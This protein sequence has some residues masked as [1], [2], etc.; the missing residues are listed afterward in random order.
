MT[1]FD[2]IRR[3]ESRGW[4]KFGVC[5]KESWGTV[6]KFGNES[7]KQNLYEYILDLKDS[8]KASQVVLCQEVAVVLAALIEDVTNDQSMAGIIA[9]A[10]QE[11]R[12]RIRNSL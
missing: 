6:S 4:V 9:A 2:K 10:K 11:E 12:N 1:N 7:L 5:L 8:Y 3:V